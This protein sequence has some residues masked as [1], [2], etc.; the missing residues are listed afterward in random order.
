[1]SEDM[2][3]VAAQVPGVL[4]AGAAHMRKIAQQNIDLVRQCEALENEV[5][6]MKLARRMEERN[7]QNDLSFEEKCASLRDADNEKLATYESAVELSAGGF[8]LGSLKDLNTHNGEKL[9][10]IKGEEYSLEPGE[11]DPL[12]EF[13][14]SGS[15]HG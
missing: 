4:S 9:A 8:T 12:D 10:T 7:I 15:A 5:R 6:V 14:L 13:V 3:K 1:M 11:S 2:D